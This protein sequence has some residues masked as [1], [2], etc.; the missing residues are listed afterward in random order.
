MAFGTETVVIDGLGR[1]LMS[2]IGKSTFLTY[3]V[4]R[5]WFLH[6]NLSNEEEAGVPLGRTLQC[7]KY[8]QQRFPNFSKRSFNHLPE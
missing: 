7:C 2:A 8:I 1:W 4:D 3:W 6:Q 5:N